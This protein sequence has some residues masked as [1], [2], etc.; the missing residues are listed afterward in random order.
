M[1]FE[2]LDRWARARWLIVAYKRRKKTAQ[3]LASKGML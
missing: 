3:Q 2:A 1:L